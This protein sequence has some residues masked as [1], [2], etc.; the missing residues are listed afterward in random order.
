M[1]SVRSEVQSRPLLANFKLKIAFLLTSSFLVAL[2]VGIRM[3]WAMPDVQMLSS[4]IPIE[5]VNHLLNHEFSKVTWFDIGSGHVFNFYRYFQ[6]LNALLFSYDSRME[7]VAVLVGYV[8]VAL[9]ILVI[10]KEQVF[11]INLATQY[12]IFLLVPI[13][14]LSFLGMGS[15][16][17]ELGTYCGLSISLGIWALATVKSVSVT[18]WRCLLVLQS[19]IIFTALGAY[20]LGLTLSSTTASLILVCSQRKRRSCPNQLKSEIF[21]DR[22]LQYSIVLG[23]SSALYVAAVRVFSAPSTEISSVQDLYSVTGLVKYVIYGN[24]GA[25]VNTSV[26]E[27]WGPDGLQPSPLL[28]GLVV[29]ALYAA[30]T[31][32]L[33]RRR[34][35][36]SIYLVTLLWYSS[37]VSLSVYPFRPYGDQ[38]MLNV[39]YGFHHKISFASLVIGVLCITPKEKLRSVLV[40]SQASFIVM[41]IVL[42]FQANRITWERHPA[43]RNYYLAKQFVVLHPEELAVDGNGLTQILVDI[44][45][46]LKAIEIQKKHSLSVYSGA[47]LTSYAPTVQVSGVEQDGW[48]LQTLVAKPYLLGKC[49]L[50]INITSLIGTGEEEPQILRISDKDNKVSEEIILNT[51]SLPLRISRE[52]VGETKAVFSRAAKPIEIGGDLRPLAARGFAQCISR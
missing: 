48:L 24:A 50:V 13:F 18:L 27:R 17:M 52:I 36:T 8:I 51:N 29:T 19:A 2:L 43:E 31:L 21:S 20:G 9:S 14:V 6:Y 49:E 47:P 46:S 15:R 34:D 37:F 25:F 28:I 26:L 42:I 40:I 3:W 4:L 35:R 12:L 22:F 32:V 38:W 10:L 7:I 23:V 41:S 1:T 45:T 39:W 11:R 44:P 33:L 30:M 5:D 16:G